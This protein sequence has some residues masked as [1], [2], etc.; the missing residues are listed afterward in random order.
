MTIRRIY[1]RLWQYIPSLPSNKLLP[2]VHKPIFLFLPS[3]TIHITKL[4]DQM[5]KPTPYRIFI[6]LFRHAQSISPLQRASVM[7]RYQYFN[8]AAHRIP[9]DS[10]LHYSLTPH[11]LWSLLLQSVTTHKIITFS[12]VAILVWSRW[13]Y[14]IESSSVRSH[15]EQ[16]RFLILFYMSLSVA[17]L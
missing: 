15:I 4:W 12:N 5:R 11:T 16:K 1:F 14:F 2:S 17:K 10:A 8:T 9:T 3:S 13:Q 7:I 6:Q